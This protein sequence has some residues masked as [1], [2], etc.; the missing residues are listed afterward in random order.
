MATSWHGL[1][2]TCGTPGSTECIAH[3]ALFFEDND[4]EVIA[5]RYA[6]CPECEVKQRVARYGEPPKLRTMAAIPYAEFR[7]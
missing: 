2:P 4:E 1:C 5:Q 3:Q 7:P 6:V